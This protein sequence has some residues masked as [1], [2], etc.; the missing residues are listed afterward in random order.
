MLHK[1]GA[2]LTETQ[3]RTARTGELEDLRNR[4]EAE[5]T[6][7]ELAERE[8]AEREPAE[9]RRM[10]EERP[11]SAGTLRLE[12]VKCGKDRCKKC[13]RGRGTHPTGISTSVAMESSRASM[14]AR[15]MIRRE[16]W[17]RS[18]AEKFAQ[19]SVWKQP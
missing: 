19:G 17:L 16:P 14:L 1:R 6:R 4:V 15:P 9:R 8:P 13:E 10:V 7:R 18:S 12:I 3:I 11:A 2:M 5:V